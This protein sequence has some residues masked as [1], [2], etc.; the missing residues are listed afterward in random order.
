MTFSILKKFLCLTNFGLDPDPDS[1]SLDP[2][3]NSVSPG[4]ETL[5]ATCMGKNNYDMSHTSLDFLW[6]LV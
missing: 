5:P 1:N 2:D 4:S 3:P 6:R